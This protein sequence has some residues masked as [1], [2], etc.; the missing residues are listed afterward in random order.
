MDLQKV[1]MLPQT[2]QFKEVVFTRRIVVLNESFVPLGK[3]QKIEP[4]AC[5][6]HEGIS[7]GKKEDMASALQA[8]L[9]IN[10]DAEKIVI[11]LD[12]SS[13]LARTKIGLYFPILLE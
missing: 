5:L 6:W 12:N 1:M 8:F 9:E 4:I 2:E 7:G 3:K 13:A 10:R 11:W